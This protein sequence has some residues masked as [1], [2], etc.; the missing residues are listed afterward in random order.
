MR[1]LKDAVVKILVAEYE[2]LLDDAENA[3]DDSLRDDSQMWTENAEPKDLAKYLAT[4]ED[5]E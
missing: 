1:E 2:F 5:D 4:E 3:V